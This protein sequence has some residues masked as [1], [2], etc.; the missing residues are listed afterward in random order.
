M[1]KFLKIFL[2]SI[3]VVF[4][5]FQFYPRSNNNLST[6][7]DPDD[8]IFHHHVPDPVQQILKR[9]CYDCHSSNTIY[10]WYSKIQPFSLWLADHVKEGKAE[11]NFS[12]FG[13]YSLRRQYR[14][15]EEINAQVKN[16]KMP[17]SSYTI[18][19]REA[20]LS[21]EEKLAIAT[22]VIALRDSFTSNYPTDSLQRRK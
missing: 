18:I 16:N 4:V 2:G 10:P 7:I 19:H 5:L 1:K 13:S 11:L 21:P 3:L 22:W 12:K 9:S 6:A 15:L 17:L 20:K 14:K 8:I